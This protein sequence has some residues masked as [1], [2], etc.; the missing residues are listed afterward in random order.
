MRGWIVSVQPVEATRRRRRTTSIVKSSRTMFVGSVRFHCQSAARLIEDVGASVAIVHALA[1]AACWQGMVLQVVPGK[2]ARLCVPIILFY[3]ERRRTVRAGR[4]DD[5]RAGASISVR[6][7]RVKKTVRWPHCS[8]KVFEWEDGAMGS[9]VGASRS[10]HGRR[11]VERGFA[12]VML[13][14]HRAARPSAR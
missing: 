2:V 6:T 13:V 7:S 3:V 9:T 1:A 10:R 11:S 8:G 4:K 5:A 14:S 12:V